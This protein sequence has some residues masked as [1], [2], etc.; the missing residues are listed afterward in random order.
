MDPFALPE[1][2]SD[3]HRMRSGWSIPGIGYGVYQTPPGLTKECVAEALKAGYRHIDC[4]QTYKNEKQVCQAIKESGIDRKEIFYTTKVN[5]K[6][7]GVGYI[8]LVLAHAP[9]GGLGCREGT[10]RA[11]VEA[12]GSGLVRSIGIS[13]Y[14]L[15]HLTELEDYRR[16]LGGHI[17]VAQYELHPWCN[18]DEIVDWFR[19]RN[20]VVEA[21]SPLARATR[22]DEPVLQELSKKLNRTPA[23]ILLRWSMQKGY[24][25]LVKSK[26]PSHIKE[27]L[28]IFDFKLS[29]EDVSRLSTKEY[30]PVSWDPSTSGL[31][32][33]GPR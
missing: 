9:F 21:F 17:D 22:W 19:K 33:P 20:V 4:A 24:V 11:L 5:P 26:T 30:S 18:R 6:I 27:N 10:W 15:D 16:R 8:D 28:E 14:G 13:N 32:N 3:A 2:P 29:E 23:Q 25:P 31:D 7:Q 12:Q 1:S